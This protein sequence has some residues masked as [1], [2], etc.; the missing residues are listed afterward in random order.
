M[1][2]GVLLAGGT[3][4]YDFKGSRVRYL[5]DPIQDLCSRVSGEGWLFDDAAARWFELPRAPGRAKTNRNGSIDQS[6][7]Y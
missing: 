4:P 2:G 6:G 5:S 7:Y 3:T 1:E